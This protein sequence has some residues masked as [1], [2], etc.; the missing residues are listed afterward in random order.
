LCGRLRERGRRVLKN[1][2]GEEQIPDP[3]VSPPLQAL[4]QHRKEN[5]QDDGCGSPITSTVSKQRYGAFVIRA[6]RIVM[7][8]VVQLGANRH[9][10]DDEQMRDQQRGY[11]ALESNVPKLEMLE[12]LR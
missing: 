11:P 2:A 10:H 12:H 6:I 7:H 3:N 9:R 5:H 8:P 4:A 1:A